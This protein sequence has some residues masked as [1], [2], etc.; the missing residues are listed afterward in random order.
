MGLV[1]HRSAPHAYASETY[2]SDFVDWVGRL[3]LSGLNFESFIPHLSLPKVLKSLGYRCVARVSM[4]VLNSFTL[5]NRFFDDYKQMPNH[6]D[7]VGIIDD[8]EFSDEQPTFFFLNLGETHYP[9][10]L[11]GEDLP[12]IPGVH[13]ACRDLAAGQ[14][15]GGVLKA[16]RGVS[17]EDFINDDVMRR[18]HDQQVRCV[19]H[20][21]G[22]IE[23]IFD[24]APADT[25][26]MIM[27]DHGEAFGES[28][29]FGHG[30]IMHEKVFE[31]PFLEGLRP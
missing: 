11:K 4:P 26:L 8:L 5:L 27:S 3:N 25:Y 31:V 15:G 24:K 28:G 9:Y 16:R 30:P 22:L 1:P 6:N 2:K 21:D 19:E 7:F 20:V 13:G 29:Y 18:L 12:Y 23:R 17:A 14:D 10:M